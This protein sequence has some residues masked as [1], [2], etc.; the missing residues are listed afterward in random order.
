MERYDGNVYIDHIGIACNDIEAS[1][2]FWRLI[3]LNEGEVDEIVEDQGVKT[4]FFDT[5]AITENE[6]PPRFEL[7]EPTGPN[8]PIG[9]FLEKRGEGVQQVCI[10]VDNIEKMIEHLISNGIK[11]IN[12]TPVKGTHDCLI[13]F[14]HPK[15]T[16]GVL[17][18]LA[19]KT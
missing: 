1:S 17:I 12:E 11:M 19:Q 6:T 4:R 3:G 13:A 10:R 2:K 7:L 5:Y 15:S 9:K 8:T 18:E 16:G 14:V